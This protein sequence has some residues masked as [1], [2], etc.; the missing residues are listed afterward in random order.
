VSLF[1]LSLV[2]CLLMSVSLPGK[3][4]N[5]TPAQQADLL[6]T[7]QKWSEAEKAYKEVL[8]SHPDDATSAMNLADCYEQSGDFARAISAYQSAA[9]LESARV[10][11]LFAMSGLYARIGN[12]EHAIEVLNKA[13]DEGFDQG[14]MVL[15]DTSLTGLR[16]DPGFQLALRRLLGE[17]FTGFD[18]VEPTKEEMKQGIQ[19]LTRTIRKQSPNPYRTFSPEEWDART[20][21]A[22]SRVNSLDTTGYF[23]ELVGLAGM[24]GDVHTAVYPDQSSKVLRDVCHLRF[25]KFSDGLYIRAAAPALSYLVGSKVLAIQGTPV[26]DA[27]QRLMSKVPTENEWMS[28]Y[29][30][31]FY[32]QFP[33]FLHAMGLGEDQRQGLWT[34]QLPSGQRSEV[35]LE[36]T[37]DVGWAG[38]INSSLGIIAPSDY[39]EG[40]PSPPPLWLKN[41]NRNY[42]FEYLSPEKTVFLQINT[43]RQDRA[44][45]WDDFVDEVF[46]AIRQS[47]AERLVIDLR[48]NG[49]GNGEMAQKLVHAII[50]TP[51]I[52]RPGHLYVLTSRITQSAGVYFAVRLEQETY[53]VF[54]GEP[55]GAHPNFFNSPRGFHPMLALPGTDLYFR[56]ANKWM[57][58]SD[59]QDDRKF[60]APDIPV[61]MSYAEYSGGKD[62]VLRAALDLSYKD[63]DKYFEDEGGR[64]IPLYF[65]WRRSDQRVAFTSE[66]WIRLK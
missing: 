60:I 36:A 24:A 65:R 29:M 47:Q 56:V 66:Q 11:G 25:W 16:N 6:Y 33:G 61:A 28:A 34:L 43:P 54:V 62:P 45:P 44:H 48:H 4:T 8:T 41:R 32:M 49:G 63:A 35:R 52:D 39:V 46:Q 22:L 27:W 3:Y 14:R 57:Q 1:R 21:S 10:F 50:A 37:E 58:N 55:I 30:V 17:G 26:D 38:A 59:N 53:S 15:R 5:G 18:R 42:W 64:P 2:V 23:V 9:K 7:S 40:H 12:K 13:I 51:A 19:L 31:Q 20:Q